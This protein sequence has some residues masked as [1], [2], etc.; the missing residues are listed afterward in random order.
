M[1]LII[2]F[3]NQISRE[4]CYFLPDGVQ[5]QARKQL[6]AVVIARQKQAAAAAVAA[7]TPIPKQKSRSQTK[8][9]M[10]TPPVPIPFG[11]SQ[12]RSEAREREIQRMAK[13]GTVSFAPRRPP[14][15]G[16]LKAKDLSSR[17]RPKSIPQGKEALTVFESSWLENARLQLALLKTCGRQL[18]MY[19]FFTTF[20]LA[21][22]TPR[23]P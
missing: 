14:R 3:F 20:A 2:V 21:R 17:G 7:S 8:P 22:S 19:G 11:A 23:H 13:H 1:S 10:Q 9:R 6:E 15:R 12:G 5:Q 18:R 4:F 16:E